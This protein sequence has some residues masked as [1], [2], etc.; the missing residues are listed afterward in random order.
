MNVVPNLKIILEINID[1]IND[2]IFKAIDY[3]KC[4]SGT[5]MT[6]SK[7]IP[8]QRFSFDTIL[9]KDIKRN[10]IKKPLQQNDEPT[11]LIWELSNIF[12]VFCF[13]L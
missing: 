12:A 13:I 1:K 10:Q 3:F 2:L 6:K 11:K 7:K 9:F 4:Y 5:D 8:C